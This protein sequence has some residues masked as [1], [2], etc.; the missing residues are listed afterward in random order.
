VLN[1]TKIPY[2]IAEHYSYVNTA[3]VKSDHKPHCTLTALH[4]TVGSAAIAGIGL[5]DESSLV[6]WQLILYIGQ[7]P[8]AA[9]YSHVAHV[10]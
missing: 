5:C 7:G 10:S 2:L 3:A 6:L 8:I 1:K 9:H 4:M